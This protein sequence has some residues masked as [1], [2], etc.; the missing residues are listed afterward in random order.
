VVKDG[1]HWEIELSWDGPRVLNIEKV[2]DAARG[3]DD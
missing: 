1:D 2:M 3:A